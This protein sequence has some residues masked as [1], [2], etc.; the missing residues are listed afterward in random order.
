MTELS[1]LVFGLE[2]LEMII[3]RSPI[4]PE[5][6]IN[7]NVQGKNGFLSAPN[8]IVDSM[9]D[10]GNFMLMQQLPRHKSGR[11][12]TS[13]F[14]GAYITLWFYSGSTAMAIKKMVG[15]VVA[16]LKVSETVYMTPK[17]MELKL[18]T[19]RWNLTASRNWE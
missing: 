14:T 2:I 7:T 1:I 9:S 4:S 6:T 17:A 3:L 8:G 16:I 19:E 11:I 10:N 18:F 15:R 12:C 13:A 5:T